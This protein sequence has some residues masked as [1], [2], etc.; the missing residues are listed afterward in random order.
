MM[1]L[2]KRDLLILFR[3]PRGWLAG[4]VFFVLFL[5][6]SSTVIIAVPI[7]FS[8]NSSASCSLLP[9]ENDLLLHYCCYS[10]KL[11]VL[12]IIY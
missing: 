10:Y 7:P 5:A 4:L 1:A 6:V 3:N 8:A 11:I 12:Y 9:G 2:I